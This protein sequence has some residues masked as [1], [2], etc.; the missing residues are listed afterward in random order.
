MTLR[1][2]PTAALLT[3]TPLGRERAIRLGALA[4]ALG[5]LAAAL[6]ASLLID[7]GG[8]DLRR[9][10]Y[11]GV[12]VT[13]LLGSASV[14]LPLPSAIAVVG[15]S[16]LLDDVAGVPAWLLVAAVAAAGNSLGELS[17]YLAGV[18]GRGVLAKQRFYPR[19]AGWMQKRGSLTLFVL[20]IIPNPLFDIAGIVAGSTRMPL[21]RFL[22]V[23]FHGKLIKNI[24]FALGGVASVAAIGNLVG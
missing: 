21:A 18:G 5:M 22:L 14:A 10:G 15:G 13:A 7:V 6:A 12:F 17:G 3:A 23:V 11:A 20:A 19:I 1:M 16:T 24:G 2:A 8:E 9:L 4:A